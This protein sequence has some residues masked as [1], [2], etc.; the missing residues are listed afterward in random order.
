MRI[1]KIR[2]KDSIPLIVIIILI[3]ISIIYMI[4]YFQILEKKYNEAQR[5]ANIFIDKKSELMLLRI[6]V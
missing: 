5:L 1:P 3:I 6:F 4:N 2:F